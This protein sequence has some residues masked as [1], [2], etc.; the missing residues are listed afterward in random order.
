MNPHT[1]RE[2]MFIP[3]IPPPLVEDRGILVIP[4]PQGDGARARN[5][6]KK[7]FLTYMSLYCP[8]NFS[9][10]V[11]ARHHTAATQRR[12]RHTVLAAVNMFY[13]PEQQ[14]QWRH[15]RTREFNL[16]C[17][18]VVNAFPIFETFDSYWPVKWL[19]SRAWQGKNRNR[20]RI[21]RGKCVAVK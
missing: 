4:E 11:V 13:Q 8:S 3:D 2:N 9:T 7:F 21:A 17:Q 16:M 18:E 19:L 14:R 1:G 15:V 12:L 5:I 20:N 6:S 10:D